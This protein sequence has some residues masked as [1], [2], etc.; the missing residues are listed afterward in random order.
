MPSLNS[1]GSGFL[2]M[3]EIAEKLRSRGDIS[4]ITTATI[5][6][7][8][9]TV[10]YWSMTTAMCWS[11]TST[12]YWSMLTAAYWSITIVF[13]QRQVGEEGVP[14]CIAW[15]PDDK[16]VLTCGASP[17]ISRW[18]VDAGADTFVYRG[19]HSEGVTGV[20]WLPDGR[21]FVSAGLD[22]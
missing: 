11:T 17:A 7:N 10:V 5:H 15:S 22:R 4:W 19:G 3:M 8:V 2:E 1:A 18:S 13:I 20:A 21:A 16:W 6:W 14:H 12:V 9:K